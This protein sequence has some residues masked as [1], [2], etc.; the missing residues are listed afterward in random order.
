M[1]SG[2]TLLVL[3]AKEAQLP[4]A[5]SAAKGRRNSHDFVAFDAAVETACRFFSVLKRAYSNATGITIYLHWCAAVAQS[6]TVRWK[7]AIE[8]IGTEQQ[9][10]DSDGFAAAA[11]A[12]VGN[13]PV[14]CGNVLVTSLEIAR[15][16]AMDSLVSGEAFRIAIS[17]DVANDT[18]I[19]DAQ[20][21]AV[22]IRET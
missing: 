17:R 3:H 9:D 13:V 21:L 14:V 10:L 16:F 6:G 18:A 11:L 20:L 15:G 2:E 12:V 8:R 5:S 4:G 22:E 1:A 19:G 7:V